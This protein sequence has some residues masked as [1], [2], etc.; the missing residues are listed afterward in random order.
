M[1]PFN[2]QFTANS[3]DVVTRDFPIE[4]S[5]PPIDDAY[6]LV[7]VSGVAAVHSVII[8]DSVLEAGGLLPAPGDSQAWRVGMNRI[9]ASTLR[10]GSNTIAIRRFGNDAF[11]VGWAVV[12]WREG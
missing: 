2:H 4:G 9:P 12:H 3:P 5:S 1:I 11:E 8:N 10:L 6:L 7:Q